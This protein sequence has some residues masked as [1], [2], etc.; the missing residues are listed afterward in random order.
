M[1]NALGALLLLS[2]L[3]LTLIFFFLIYKLKNIILY[4]VKSI[5]QLHCIKLYL[6]ELCLEFYGGENIRILKRD[7]LS[8]NNKI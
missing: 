7:T 1:H 5:L 8:I 2:S 3:M 6:L 4:S